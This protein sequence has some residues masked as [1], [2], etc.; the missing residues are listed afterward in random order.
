MLRAFTL[1]L[2]LAIG[3]ITLEST[4][5]NSTAEPW[6]KD[7]LMEPADLASLINE[8]KDGD[9]I[10]YSIGPS[11]IIK[12][13]V[14]IGAVRNQANLQKLETQLQKL[15]KNQELVIYCGCCPFKNCPN[16]RPAF[17]L[18]NKMKFTNHKLLNLPN[19][20]KTDWIDK[21]YPMMD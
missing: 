15:P 1:L 6:N 4:I 17:S 5:W 13:S 20:V 9:L 3:G 16:V 12:N 11:A 8:G 10:I 14:N 7:Q 21:G 19:N 2:I 18:L